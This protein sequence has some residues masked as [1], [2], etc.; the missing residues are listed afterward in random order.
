MSRLIAIEWDNRE[1]RVAVASEKRGQA[2]VEDV[3]AIPFEP[4]TGPKEIGRQLAAGLSAHRIRGG[5]TLVAVGRNSIELKL[6]NLPPAPDDDLPEMVRF[7]SPREF[8]SWADGWPLDY[9]SLSEDPEQQRMVLAATIAPEIVKQVEETC[10]IAGLKPENLVLRPCAAASLLTRTKKLTGD[11]P[12][13]LIDLLADEMDLTVTIRGRVVF[14]RTA[15]L[16]NDALATADFAKPLVAEVR[17]TIGAAQNQLGGRRVER[18][19]LCAGSDEQNELAR[20]LAESLN[21][22]TE[23][24]DPFVEVP[25]AGNLEI[26]RGSHRGRFAPVLGMVIDAAAESQH[27]IDFLNPKRRPE[28]PSQR[29]RALIYATAAVLLVGLFGAWYWSFLNSLDGQIADLKNQNL[30][31]QKTADKFKP[32]VDKVAA[33]E[34]WQAEN[35][36]WLNE[37]KR[38]AEKLP[39][40]D[41]VMFT[42]LKL[43]AQTGGG[44]KIAFNGLVKETA[45]VQ[46]LENSLRDPKHQVESSY[47][48]P[49]DEVKPYKYEFETGVTVASEE[50]Q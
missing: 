34:A 46:T 9:V 27:A 4:T 14:T 23:L 43:N 25:Q 24:F 3:F 21:L 41:G 18:V 15:R 22:P 28:K 32:V 38:M 50:A 17:R 45:M 7:Q 13:L 47:T 26:A 10:Q 16:P 33:I 5:N 1:A 49:K 37:L 42:D 40:A 8:T 11:E 2:V 39:P 12:Q 36:N 6:F 20:H 29:P 48:A 31:K 35:V 19:W 44:G 30:A